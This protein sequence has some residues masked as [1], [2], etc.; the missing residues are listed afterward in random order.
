[1][2][3]DG[4]YIDLD[5]IGANWSGY[6]LSNHFTEFE[7]IDQ[8]N[9]HPE[10]N[11]LIR[12]VYIKEPHVFRSLKPIKGYNKVLNAVKSLGIEWKILTAIGKDHP[13][14][15]IARE[16]KL[17]FL[18]HHF[19]IERE[20]VI[21]TDDS[22][23]KQKYAGAGKILIDDFDK[24]IKQW[25]AAGGLGILVTANLYDPARLAHNILKLCI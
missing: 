23:D 12:N 2:N 7:S 13:D 11:R 6:M 14:P 17:Y 9:N 20:Q 21:I 18:K 10:M 24:N 5:G 15:E 16:D 3:V 19:N 1:M 4:I 25:N 8:L 22:P